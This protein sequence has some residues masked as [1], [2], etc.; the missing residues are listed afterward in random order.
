VYDGAGERIASQ[1]QMVYVEKIEGEF[2]DVDS[3]MGVLEQR[4]RCEPGFVVPKTGW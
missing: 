3:P 2:E 4:I 1:V